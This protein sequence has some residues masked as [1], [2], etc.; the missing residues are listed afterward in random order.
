MA[1]AGSFSTNLKNLRWVNV[2]GTT[3]SD[4]RPLVQL[5]NLKV[6]SLIFTNVSEE[7]VEML[8]QALPDCEMT[9]E[10]RAMSN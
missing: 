4:L 6:L 8:K 5:T 1:K 7:N 3:V 9:Y 10:P 2:S